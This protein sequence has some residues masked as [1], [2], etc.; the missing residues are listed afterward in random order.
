MQLN[1]SILSNTSS[2]LLQPNDIFRPKNDNIKELETNRTV[3][4]KQQQKIKVDPTPITGAKHV[5]L[6]SDQNINKINNNTIENEIIHNFQTEAKINKTKITPA[7]IVTKQLIDPK[8]NQKLT[9]NDVAN[10]SNNNVAIAPIAK[11]AVKESTKKKSKEK[12]QKAVAEEKRRLQEEEEEKKRLELIAAQRKAK[13][14]DQNI[15]RAEQGPK[16]NNLAASVGKMTSYF[17]SFIFLIYILNYFFLLAPWSNI[18]D[19]ATA[20]PTSSPLTLAEIQKAEREH[21]SEMYRLE[22][23]QQQTQALLD[24]QKQTESVLKWKLKPQN[25]TKS[26]AEIQ[27]EESKARQTIQQISAA[28]VCLI[29]KKKQK[30]HL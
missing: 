27:A 6:K 18:S 5:D 1:S 14:V 2:E 9:A 20:N 8:V 30:F 3:T 12:D 11:S 26:L 16:R 19:N 4:V 7:A 23:A 22:Q 17:P 13:L 24:Q 15:V 28:N 21:R 29:E 10:K 25:Q